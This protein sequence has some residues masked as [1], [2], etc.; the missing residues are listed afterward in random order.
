M[1]QQTQKRKW[2]LRD[3]GIVS[4]AKE[5]AFAPKTIIT[6][7]IGLL[8]YVA[9]IVGSMVILVIGFFVCRAVK[10]NAY[11]FSDYV[12][13]QGIIIAM[14]LLVGLLIVLTLIY[15]RFIEKR[16]AASMGL[17]RKGWLRHYTVGFALGLGLVAISELLPAWLTGTADVRGLTPMVIVFLAGYIIQASA[18]EIFFRG[19]LLP[20][21]SAKIGVVWGVAITTLLTAVELIFSPNSSMFSI[22]LALFAGLFFALYM[23]RTGSIFGVCAIHAAWNFGMGLFIVQYIG[24]YSVDYTIV[25]FGGGM[26]VYPALGGLVDLIATLVYIVG[27]VLLLFVGKKRLVVSVPESIPEIDIAMLRPGME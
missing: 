14:L 26:P 6:L 4:A 10:G 17:L 21:I 8:I 5:A 20:S 2:I 25:Q 23:L 1:D 24:G 18:S 7:L 12:G 9:Y 11:P 13:S 3:S 15:V 19:F 22:A 16:S 27:C